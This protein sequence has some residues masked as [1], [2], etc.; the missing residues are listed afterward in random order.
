[1]NTVYFLHLFIETSFT[2]RG[3]GIHDRVGR[4]WRDPFFHQIS[5]LTLLPPAVWVGIYRKCN[6]NFPFRLG[7]IQ[8][9]LFTY[10]PF[11]FGCLPQSYS[12]HLIWI[13]SCVSSPP[14][15]ILFRRSHVRDV[16]MKR[17]RFIDD[18]CRVRPDV[19]AD[20]HQFLLS[21]S[22]GSG[23][24]WLG[25]GQGVVTRAVISHAPNLGQWGARKP[26]Y[27]SDI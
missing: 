12:K 3:H 16:A 9:H 15:K 4:V 19:T 10:L 27:V 22:R 14:G 5:A 23:E 6:S 1:M 18:Y 2:G 24:S 7:S 17:L 8:A 21:A 11:C 26:F 13:M 25:G 20:F